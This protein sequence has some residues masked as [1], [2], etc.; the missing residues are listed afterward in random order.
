MQCCSVSTNKHCS[1]GSNDSDFPTILQT[2][3]LQVFSHFSTLVMGFSCSLTLPLGLIWVAQ[4]V[5]GCIPELSKDPLGICSTVCECGLLYSGGYYVFIYL[6]NVT[7]I[8]ANL[9][10]TLMIRS[11]RHSFV[12]QQSL[13]GEGSVPYGLLSGTSTKTWLYKRN[14]SHPARRGLLRHIDR[15]LCMLIPVKTDMAP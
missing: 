5:R 1:N 3:V 7:Y 13:A 2:S 14:Y 6:I 10:T 4:S 15:H 12:L 8:F 9:E 11:R